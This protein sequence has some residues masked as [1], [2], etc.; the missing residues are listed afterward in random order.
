MPLTVLTYS[1]SCRYSPTLTCTSPLQLLIIQSTLYTPWEGH[2]HHSH[3]HHHHHHACHPLPQ[4]SHPSHPNPHPPPHP[5]PQPSPS[6]SPFPWKCPPHAH[7][8]NPHPRRPQAH[9][10]PQPT[11]HPRLRDPWRG[12]NRAWCRP[13]RGPPQ[14]APQ[15][16]HS[17]TPAP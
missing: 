2:H 6:L 14:D 1:T 11:R 8:T 5:P 7:L 17:P 15:R 9:P 13:Y 12:S 16:A 4:S 3:P 10:P